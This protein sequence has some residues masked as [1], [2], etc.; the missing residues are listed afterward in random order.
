M[1]EHR[2]PPVYI[3]SFRSSGR[4]LPRSGAVVPAR[5]SSIDVTFSSPTYRDPSAVRFRYRLGP[6]DS[7][8]E[9]LSEPRLSLAGLSPGT[10]TL[11]VVA[12]NGAG[13]QSLV[14]VSLEFSVQPRL[15]ETWWFRT[16]LL[17]C[18]M[19]MIA[20]IPWLRSRRLE[21]EHRILNDLVQE[22]T[23][24]LAEKTAGLE[25]EIAGREVAEEERH[26]L[27]Q[28]LYQA[29]KME[30]I[31]RLAGGIAHDFNNLLTAVVGHAQLLEQ[32]L[33]EGNPCPDDVKEIQEAA[34]RGAS[35]VSQLLAYSRQQI[36][37][38]ELVDLNETVEASGRLLQRVIGDDVV[39]R[40]N[41][42]DAPARVRFDPTQLDQVLVN[43]A[44]N[45]K[46]A[47]PSG[48]ELSFTVGRAEVEEPQ[49]EPGPDTV[50]SGS[51]VTLEVRDTGLGMDEEVL[52]RAFDPFFTTKEA[53][54]GTGL[55]LATVY[56]AVHQSGGF[57]QVNSVAGKGTAFVLYFP[58]AE[59]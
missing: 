28:Q 41:V 44:V 51:Y 33:R 5:S 25:R 29:Q 8:S 3:E 21:R 54:R 2:P 35:L 48:G 32:D 10:Y 55:G 6:D 26:K 13:Q 30:A 19:S 52:E 42:A 9:P 18:V 15:W 37:Q 57:V 20:S 31:G 47:M 50:E 40:V 1:A 58:S 34:R 43:L 38:H 11:D 7:W 49:S 59:G 14:P 24:E 12:E 16:V 4:E 56:G 39:L 17:L 22:R 46:D 23:R 53:G 36:I 27:E 45:A